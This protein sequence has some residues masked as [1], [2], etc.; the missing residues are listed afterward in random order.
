MNL[1]RVIGPAIGAAIYAR[2][3]AALVFAINA[4]TYLFAVAG[5]V[6]ARYDRGRADP[7]M[8]ETGLARL[9]SGFRM[10]WADP[11]VR[12]LVTTLFTFSLFSLAF[13]G[14]MPAIAAKNL[15]IRPKSEAY[16]LLYASF[17]LGAAIGAICV[18]TVLAHRPKARIARRGLVAFAVLLAA[19]G[20]VHVK[21]AAY[22]LVIVLGFF[23][24]SVVT[25]MAT[26]LQQHLS[27]NVRGRIMAIWMMAFGGTVPVGVLLGG[28]VANHTSITVVLL[29]GAAW[30]LLL[31]WYAD[32]VAVGAPG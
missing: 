31:A 20:S 14:L 13:V 24:F 15:H 6:L 17:G 7:H 18:G 26:V 21:A 23:Y 30:A 2:S 16:G 5:L 3:G 10:A 4:V 22:P 19:F 12:R 28:F 9:L 8:E 25:S 32:F 1:S 27:D 11:L 29:I